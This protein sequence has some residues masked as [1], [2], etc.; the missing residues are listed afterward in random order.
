MAYTL[1]M[2]LWRG[3]K[4]GGDAGNGEPGGGWMMH[5]PPGDPAARP[6]RLTSKN[7]LRRRG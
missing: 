6:V 4:S 7:P 3:D 5:P 2:R 1:K